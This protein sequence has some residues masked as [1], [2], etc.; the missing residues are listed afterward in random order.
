MNSSGVLSII[1]FV[2]GLA[3]FGY[4]FAWV[5]KKPSV[6]KLDCPPRAGRQYHR[7]RHALGGVL[8]DGLWPC[9]FVQS[10]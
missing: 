2:Y 10:V 6:S 7:Y 8:P 1:T 4:I 5:F 9:A 3:G